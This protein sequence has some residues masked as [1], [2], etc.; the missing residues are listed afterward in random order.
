MKVHCKLAGCC[1]ETFEY[2]KNSLDH[3]VRLKWLKYLKRLKTRISAFLDIA[4]K[5]LKNQEKMRFSIFC[6]NNT[7]SSVKGLK[8]W[9]SWNQG[10]QLFQYCSHFS[11]KLLKCPKKL[12]FSK[13]IQQTQH[14]KAKHSWSIAA[15]A[16]NYYSAI[17]YSNLYIDWLQHH[18]GKNNT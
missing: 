18:E 15:W 3:D 8:N 10:S 13:L 7:S 11:L 6:R 17:F 14:Y 5:W 12:K 2:H 9:K 4:A 16:P 1:E